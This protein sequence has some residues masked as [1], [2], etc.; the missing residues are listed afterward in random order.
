MCSRNA[1]LFTCLLWAWTA[2][3]SPSSATSGKLFD[4]APIREY[5]RP[6]LFTGAL[7]R[8][9]PLRQLARERDPMCTSSQWGVV[10]T[11]FEPGE[12]IRRMVQNPGWCLVVVADRKTS[13]EWHVPGARLL[14]VKEQE[15]M[16]VLP[17]IP[18][19]T[20]GRKNI[21]FLFAIAQGATAIWDFDDDNILYGNL[22]VPGPW[23][24]SATQVLTKG[25]INP[26]E[27]MGAATTPC[28]PR[29][30]PLEQLK[31]E[32]QVHI[33]HE[34]MSV[35]RIVVY[36]SLANHDPDFDALF[37]LTQPLPFYFRKSS[38]TTVVLPVGAIAPY[39]AQATM[40]LLPA[41]WSLLLPI[42]VHGRVSD[43]WRGYVA[44]RLMWDLG[45]HLAFTTPLVEQIR[46]AH[47]YLADMES[48]QPL[49]TQT[50]ALL[51]FLQEWQ[52]S[53]PT[54]P[55]RMEEL[56]VAL[57]ERGYIE[58]QDIVLIQEWIQS[59]LAVDYLFPPLLKESWQL[60][61]AFVPRTT[62]SLS[63]TRHH[64]S[65]QTRVLVTGITSMLGVQLATTLV[66]DRSLAVFGIAASRVDMLGGILHDMTLI[67]GECSDLQVLLRALEVSKPAIIFHLDT[68]HLEHTLHLLEAVRMTNASL[69][70]R[71]L[72]ASSSEAYEQNL[73]DSVASETSPLRPHSFRGV[74][75]ATT[76]LLARQ[77]ALSYSLDVVVARVF[78]VVG[79]ETNDEEEEMDAGTSV[80]RCARLL[81]LQDRGLIPVKTPVATF[82]SFAQDWVDGEE[83][84]SI[85][86]QLARLGHKNE[87]YNVGSGQRTQASSLLRACLRSPSAKQH[88]PTDPFSF[89][90]NRHVLA[91]HD[92]YTPPGL[93]ANTSKL[94]SLLGHV[95]RPPSTQTIERIMSAWKQEV[96]RR[97]PTFEL[98]H[99]PLFATVSPPPVK[100]EAFVKGN[101]LITG[102]SGMIGSHVAREIVQTRPHLRVFGIVRPRS[103][104]IYLAGILDRIT[105][106]TADIL[107][108]YRMRQVCAQVMPEFVFHFA[109]QAI[110]SFSYS[111]PQLTLDTNV[112]GTRNLLE[113]LRQAG[114]R[115]T[116]V[117]LAGSSTEYGQTADVWPEDSIPE[118]APM[119]PVSPYGVSK[120]A[121]ELLGNLYFVNERMSIITARFFI[122]VGVGGTEALAM[123]EFCRQIALIERGLQE[124]VLRHGNLGT[125]RDTSDLRQSAAV[126]VQLAE[127]GE[128]GE[129]YNVGTGVAVSTQEVLNVALGLARVPIQTEV[130]Q[131]RLRVYDEKVLVANISKLARLTGWN[132]VL[133]LTDTILSI[134]TFW[135]H[136]VDR[137][138]PTKATILPPSVQPR[139]L[140]IAPIVNYAPRARWA[141]GAQQRSF[142]GSRFGQ[143]DLI[144]RT[145]GG[146]ITLFAHLLYSIEAFWPKHLGRVIFV[147]DAE[148]EVDAQAHLLLPDWIDVAW[149][150]P[151]F[152]YDKWTK[153]PGY[154]RQSWS[155]FYCDQYSTAP[156]VMIMDSDSIFV[157]YGLEELIFG[158]EGKPRII[159]WTPSV[160]GG[161]T[162]VRMGFP[163]TPWS[164][165]WNLP[166]VGKRDL[167]AKARTQAEQHNKMSLPEIFATDLETHANTGGLSNFCALDSTA[168]Y[169]DRDSYD[170]ALDCSN[171]ALRA[172]VHFGW[173]YPSGK[174]W[175]NKY[176]PDRFRLLWEYQSDA[177]CIAL[178]ILITDAQQQAH[179]KWQQCQ[180]SSHCVHVAARR[181]DPML[182]WQGN[183]DHGKCESQLATL[184]A[185]LVRAILNTT[186]LVACNRLEHVPFQNLPYVSKVRLPWA[187]Q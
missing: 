61:P 129:A 106:L 95:P 122:Q 98:L 131:G 108:A 84:A 56:Y 180:V 105:L 59:L 142:V 58:A 145:W 39:N 179:V 153:R 103:N 72:V 20:F 22:T 185:E 104:L 102:I 144:V 187:G 161:Q 92:S 176:E 96:R 82:D 151:P 119:I 114:L 133:N 127:L 63:A 183:L 116:R 75:A 47:N 43:I 74:L 46:N 49:Y 66:A 60:Y 123:P 30:F 118:H 53:A 45:L 33:Q 89:S 164:G 113:G 62:L 16:N 178:Y 78:P 111:V 88:A 165:M 158:K 38:Q 2:H 10:T 40:H 9:E 27:L 11:I 159:S 36:Q 150:E 90:G 68:R 91:D 154:C 67:Q 41:F 126:I 37:R 101:V 166:W 55:G 15:E 173:L 147:F 25:V 69:Q 21:G 156:F 54:L 137:R 132:P 14:T 117:L 152:N 34:R 42:T 87:V 130:E 93:I 13:V 171:A 71:I 35:E 120:V 50:P 128:P 135:R 172:G 139:E 79:P 124:A 143:V 170:F 136:E 64:A 3:G 70:T 175:K 86:F 157:T 146:D 149:E 80:Q 162:I 138:Y 29:G 76:E 65:L 77:Y 28:W 26:Y 6:L 4:G 7:P 184:G 51:R 44:Q 134:L 73:P 19:N 155:N 12:A 181:P 1:F 85:L 140:E 115:K 31:E 100:R 97:Y 32:G 148:S 125:K 57:Y 174:G 8:A 81:T 169:T 121:T 182:S 99:A 109:A 52:G 23:L 18:Y 112:R 24:A 83:A 17:S 141:S 186:R 160:W 94:H 163:D 48:E 167:F 177:T 107:D 5:T 110:N 168:W